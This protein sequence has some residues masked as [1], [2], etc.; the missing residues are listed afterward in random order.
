[1]IV[2]LVKSITHGQTAIVKCDNCENSFSKRLS[3]VERYE[4]HFCKDSCYREW[5]K[6]NFKH[7]DKSKQLFSEQRAG[8]KNAR[9]NGGRK[10]QHGYVMIKDNTHP[11]K[12]ANGYIQEHRLVMEKHL[13]RY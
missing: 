12:D 4:H 13:N 2:E 9:W 3:Q 5:Y 6:N 8:D 7:S 10:L 11:N 1:M